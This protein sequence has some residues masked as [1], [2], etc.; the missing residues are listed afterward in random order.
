MICAG[1]AI[2]GS[3]SAPA[4]TMIRFG[5]GSASLNNGAP[6][7]GQNDRRI[8]EPLSAL[9]VKTASS[10]ETS[11]AFLGKMALTVAEP[12]PRYWHTRHQHWRTANGAAAAIVN[13]T[14][15]HRHPPLIA[16]CRSSFAALTIA[17][18]HAGRQ[19]LASSG[20]RRNSPVSTPSGNE[21][22]QCEKGPA[23]VTGC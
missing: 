5:R 17:G 19:S 1:L 8:T 18:A 4:R 13:R 22:Q 12:E 15:P 10:P 23:A 9:D 11:I 14:L 3:S 21:D 7:A 16:I 2:S 6:H 20:D